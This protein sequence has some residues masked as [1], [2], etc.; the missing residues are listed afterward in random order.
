[1]NISEFKKN[2][3]MIIDWIADYFENIEKYPVKSKSSPGEVISKLPAC[4]PDRA[5][6]FEKIFGDFEKIIMPGITHWQSPSFFAYF[7]ANNSFPSILGEL[8][9]SALGAQC[10][11]WATSPAAAELEEAVMKQLAKIIGL[12]ESFCGVIEDTAST[13]TLCAALSARE[14]YS[15]YSINS[16][17]FGPENKFTAYCS[18]QAHSSIEKAVKIAGIGKN[19]LRLIGCDKNYAMM[20][21]EIF[22]V[23]A[24]GTTGSTAID[25]LRAIG[26]IC[27]KYGIWLHVD[28]AYAGSALVLPE[29]RY[30]INGVEYA[31][32][33]VFNPH[34]WLFTNFDCS[35]YFVK[36][37]AALIKTFEILPEYLKTSEKSAV[38][39]YRD[40]GIQLGRR[41]R[42]LKLW[43]VLRSF[44]VSGLRKIIKKHI[45]LAQYFAEKLSAE[46]G[47][48]IMAPHPL[49]V[50]CFRFKPRA[51]ISQE[52][53][54]AFNAG[55]LEKLN[56]SGKLYLS[57]TKLG[58]D[59][60]IRMAIGQ[61]GT[62]KKHVK[63]ALDTIIKTAKSMSK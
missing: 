47:F 21:S 19:R 10:M 49:S 11:S 42:S 2:G 50:V 7:P 35:A 60:V 14:K 53:I 33:F 24:I 28:A 29:M 6:K 62:E 56:S 18:G 9:S 34:K 38:N 5:E 41:F 48:E 30:M 20:P 43:F 54:D 46:N 55:L 16:E 3:H 26:R 15:D 40:W 37:K 59:F 31:D 27:K 51:G 39:N 36:D 63:A 25:P 32:S 23:A 52:K 4:A 57:H 13:S 61:T 58:K 17:G 44:G 45:E 1:M 22:A 8:L 12:P